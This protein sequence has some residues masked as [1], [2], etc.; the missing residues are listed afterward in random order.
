MQKRYL[1]I[2]PI[3]LT[4]A[5]GIYAYNS[6]SSNSNGMF[7][8]TV[9]ESS[10]TTSKSLSSSLTSNLTSALISVKISS[11]AAMTTPF[12]TSESSIT[13]K[14]ASTL[15][16]V[17][18]DD[19]IFSAYYAKATK[20]VSAMSLNEKVGQMFLVR[21]PQT[22]AVKDI[23]SYHLG[24]F[25]LY[26]ADFSN[27]TA[28]NVI[29]K[30]KS[31]QG[32]SSIPMVMA[33]DEE[34]GTVVRISS[35]PLLAAHKFLSPQ[36]IYAKGGLNAIRSD[37]LNKAKMLK[38]YGI[39]LNLAPVAD[40]SVNPSDYIYK[41]ALGKPAAETGKY[42]ATV[43][44]AMQASGLSSTLKHFPG[45]GNNVNTH[46]G[47][48]IDKRPY[49]T[50]EKSDFVPFEDG[51]N[52]NAESILVSHNIVNC[53]DK[54]TPASLSPAV[55]RILRNTLH[56][57]GIIMT[58]DLSMDAIKDYTHN[59]DP[60]VKAVLAGNDM[61]MIDNFTVGYNAVIKAVKTGMISQ[62]QLNDAVC[63]ILA[64]KYAMG[65]IL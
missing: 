35:N 50:F 51:I 52:A 6:I 12:I 46:T 48:S 27:K 11:S 30:I 25:V 59:T 23:K 34:G 5:V 33:V 32:A 49:S 3:I 14:T 28:T 18:N 20:K 26:G 22:N 38:K 39:N 7:N 37:T 24:G 31:Y 58:D 17:L 61:L 53:M 36:A 64:W 10:Y 63:R 4:L 56:F 65:I 42:V 19:G 9:S 8:Q 13:T 40:V 2:F 47:I 16:N 1:F 60:A 43:V 57:T 21:C 45:Y 41:R 15:P 54:S 62:Q 55:H 44:K 29:S